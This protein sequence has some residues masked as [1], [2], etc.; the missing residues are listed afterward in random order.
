MHQMNMRFSWEGILA[1]HLVVE[2]RPI[3][4]KSSNGGDANFS[5]L[6]SLKAAIQKVLNGVERGYM[7][8]HYTFYSAK[9]QFEPCR[10]GGF[11]ILFYL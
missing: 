11:G 4:C 5:F 7:I 6:F 8:F 1:K 2:Y 9:F 10:H 3:F